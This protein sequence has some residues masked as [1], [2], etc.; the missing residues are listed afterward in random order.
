MAVPAL[1]IGLGGTGQWAV[2]YL[3]KSLLETYGRIPAE[4]KLRSFDTVKLSRAGTA[5]RGM[6]GQHERVEERTVAGVKLEPGEYIHVGGYIRD[7]VRDI[8]QDEEGEKFPH[9][10][11]WFQAKYYLDNLPDTQFHLDEGAGQFRQLGRMAIFHDIKATTTSLIYGQLNDTIQQLQR[12]TNTGNLQVFI[13]GSLAGGTGA[14]MFVDVAHLVRQIASQ[15]ARMQVTVRG[16]LVLPDAFTG[17]IPAG[18]SVKR[19]MNARA[20]AA[21]RENKRFAVSFDWDMGYPIHYRAPTQGRQPDPVLEGAL[22]GQLFDSLY[23]I[24]GY[25][26]NFPLYSVKLENGVAPSVSDMIAA[27]LDDE[28][29]GP[30]QEHTKNLQAVL[31]QRGPT[32]GIPHYGSLGTY[33]IVLPIFHIVEAYS[34][35][36]AL[37]ALT[38]LLQPSKID[39]R[40]GLPSA[41]AT[42]RNRETGEGYSGANAARDFLKISSIVNPADPGSSVENTQLTP[43]LADISER[44]AANPNPLLETLAVRTLTEWDQYFA[45]TGSAEDILAARTR[46]EIELKL[47]LVDEVPASKDTA[48]REKPSDGVHR[49]EHGVRMHKN[50]HLGAEQ[51]DT[52]QRT[53]GKYRDALNEYAAVHMNRFRRMLIYKSSEILNGRAQNDPI[54]AKGGKVGHYRDFLAELSR[55]LDQ[56]YQAMMRVMERRRGQGQ[57]RSQA[58]ASAQ[59]GLADMKAHAEDTRPIFGR[60]DKTQKQYLEAEQQLIDIHKVEI[61]EQVVTE[62]IKQMA[63]LVNSAR[64]SL[65]EW[66]TLLCMGQQSVYGQLQSARIQI[67][68]NRDR[69]A[70]IECRMVLGARKGGKENANDE[71][72]QKFKRYEE[73]R[74]QFYVHDNGDNQI[75]TV[76]DA[77]HWDVSGELQRG[78]P[79]FKLALAFGLGQTTVRKMDADPVKESVE[80]LLSHTRR[81][82]DPMKANESVAGYLFYAYSSP[83]KLAQMIHAHSGPLLSHDASGPVPANYLRVWHGTESAQRDFLRTML[84]DLARQ[85]GISDQ[86]KFARLVNSNDRF[87]CTLVHTIDLIELDTISAYMSALPE[88]M[89]YQ[90]EEGAQTNQRTILHL[91]PAEVNAVRYEQRL[92]QLNQNVRIFTDEVVWQMEKLDNLRLFLMCVAYDLVQEQNIQ[93]EDKTY[94]FYQLSWSTSKSGD[95]TEV[96]LTT[97]T[98]DRE[99]SFL[100]AIHTFNYSGKDVRKD[101]YQKIDYPGIRATLRELQIQ[102]VKERSANG[103]LG[104]SNPAI[105][106]WLKNQDMSLGN[107]VWEWVAQ[108]DRLTDL[109]QEWMSALPGLASEARNDRSAQSDYDLMSIFVLVLGDELERLKWR[110]SGNVPAGDGSDE[111]KP[112][113]SLNSEYKRTNPFRRRS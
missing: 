69:D 11:S 96:W 79:V 16:F 94:D 82:F 31:A 14:G 92:I 18:N 95:K 28:S 54:L 41:L 59:N 12:D 39:E 61:M 113:S 46:A 62:T 35:Q 101:Y 53:G 24:D 104:A 26:K 45:P 72:Y 85:S 106:G 27:I 20:F 66:L 93:R 6:G 102:D 36:L 100:E 25:R 58:I 109:K 105:Q 8:A 74:Y 48:P 83:E 68:A 23:Y 75:A 22:K 86:E 88:Y 50:V 63:D 9:L 51:A 15:T 37:E 65:E 111:D 76:L 40:T 10:R 87:S 55:Y 32:R 2:L 91:F 110:I 5:D 21:M 97:P 47:R 1:V 19:G 112:G 38:V 3:K 34:H 43:Q 13:V 17:S 4:V 80:R 64:A 103:T 73:D 90:G 67:D 57:G 29:S 33:S 60:A 42:D 7:F 99:L 81:V 108:H 107:P 71:D 70:D 30:F 49:I 89:G 56:S 44:F 52:G 77:L 84:G 98:S 78:K